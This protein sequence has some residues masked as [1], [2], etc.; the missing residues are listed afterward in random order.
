MTFTVVNLKAKGGD[1][2][3]MNKVKEFRDNLGMSQDEL[4]KKSGVSRTIISKIE[5]GQK[6]DVK[7]STLIA[8]SKALKQPISNIFLL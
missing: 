7:L 3:I 2:L 6:V 4:A 1:S 8:L 5:N